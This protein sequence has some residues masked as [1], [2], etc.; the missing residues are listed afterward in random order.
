MT[1][2]VVA[3]YDITNQEGY[4]AYLQTVAPTL[5]SHGAEILAADY[6]T[7]VREGAPGRVTIVIRFDS[8]EAARGWYESPEYQEIVHHRTDNS[9]GFLVICEERR[10][11]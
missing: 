3:N 1:G 6:E 5:T 11:P 2:Y 10:R 9:D 7:E 4:Q 8:P